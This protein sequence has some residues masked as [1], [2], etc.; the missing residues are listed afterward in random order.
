MQQKKRRT[1]ILLF[2]T[3]DCSYNTLCANTA[4]FYTYGLVMVEQKC[5]IVKNYIPNLIR[6]RSISLF[7]STFCLN[8]LKL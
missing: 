5:R 3:P 1:F 7:F 2:C 8:E 6:L 4:R